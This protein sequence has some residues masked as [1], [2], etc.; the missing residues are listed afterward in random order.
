MTFWPERRLHPATKDSVDVVDKDVEL[1]VNCFTD[2]LK[3]LEAEAMR[4]IKST[5]CSCSH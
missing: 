3:K 2:L 1:T 4:I 5:T